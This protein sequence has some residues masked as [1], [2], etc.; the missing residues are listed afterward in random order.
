M[1]PFAAGGIGTYFTFP[2]IG[3]WYTTL[4]KPLFSPPNYVFG[5]V[6]TVLYLLMGLSLYMVWNS[7]HSKNKE[8][9]IKLFLLQIV[10]N[11]SWSVVFFGL[12][13]PTLAFINII[14]LWIGIALTIRAFFKVSR[15]AAYLLY[16]YIAWVS[17]AAVL[18][19]AIVFLN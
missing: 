15:H 14:A 1:L 9:A 19:L 6:W 17:I 11:A 10:L 5:P 18:N 8:T 12:K 4:N 7:K 13:N 2:A 16:P 3:S